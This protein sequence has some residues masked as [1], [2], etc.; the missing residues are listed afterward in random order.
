VPPSATNFIFILWEAAELDDVTARLEGAGVRVRPFG[1][2]TPLS[3][4][5]R[6]TVAP[7]DRMQLLL[8][9]LDLV[10]AGTI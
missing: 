6:A 3:N 9:A 4:G 10:A 2:P 5:L 1:G 7:W 8:D